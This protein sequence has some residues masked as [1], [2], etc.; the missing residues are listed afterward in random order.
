MIILQVNPED[1]AVFGFF[2]YLARSIRT[3]LQEQGADARSDEA[4]DNLLTYMSG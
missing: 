1:V 3:Y 2:A 4:F